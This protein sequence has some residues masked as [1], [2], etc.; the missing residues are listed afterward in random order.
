MADPWKGTKPP[1]YRIDLSLPPAERYVAVARLYRERMRSLTGMFDELIVGISPRIPVNLVHYLARLFL[2]KL[3]TAEETAEIQ[4][5][6]HETGIH[7]YLLICLNVVLDLLMGCTS[8]GVRCKKATGQTHMLHFRTLDWG[9]DPLR[10]LI[11]QFDFIRGDEPQKVLATSITYVGF[12]GVLTGVKQDL[13]VSLNFRPVHDPSR[14]LSFYLN[15]LFVLLGLRQSISSL[16]RQCIMPVSPEKR[17]FMSA[18]RQWCFGRSPS[19]GLKDPTLQDIIAQV[20][21]LPTTAAYLIFCDGKTAVIM[22]KDHRD[23]FV[24]TSESFIVT[25]NHDQQPGSKPAEAVAEDK[26]QHAGLGLISADIPSMTDLIEESNERLGC[27]QEKWDAK[28]KKENSRRTWQDELEQTEHPSSTRSSLRLRKK[29]SEE[30]ENKK[31]KQETSEDLD[32]S[33]TA[34]EALKWLNTIP[35]LNECTHYAALMTPSEGRVAWARWYSPEML[36]SF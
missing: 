2:R 33:I 7:L 14:N 6:S 19:H 29:K 17:S 34:S 25:T 10:E 9:M 5:I 8:G 30:A 15:H 27:M 3:Y 31:K 16:L 11:V 18:I 12:V 32:V 21:S 36:T 24:R 26:R 1:V 22:E 28:V 20:P 4:G 13:S 35:I 23:A